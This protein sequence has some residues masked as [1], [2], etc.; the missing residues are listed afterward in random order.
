MATPCSY[1]PKFLTSDLIIGGVFLF[2][3][4]AKLLAASQSSSDLYLDLYS[5]S[6]RVGFLQ[7]P[8]HGKG[9]GDQRS[10]SVSRPRKSPNL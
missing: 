10:C 9:D 8:N 7:T 1:R 2:I 3:T 4:K 6:D 5:R